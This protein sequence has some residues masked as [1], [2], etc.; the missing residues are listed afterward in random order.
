MN[1]FDTKLPIHSLLGYFFLISIF[2]TF[3]LGFTING[4]PYFVIA[5]SLLVLPVTYLLLEDFLSIK[6]T[7]SLKE[8]AL[9]LT[10]GILL[11]SLLP[12]TS[13]SLNTD[14]WY[15]FFVAY[16][17]LDLVLD[18]LVLYF[19]SLGKQSVNLIFHIYS[20]VLS[21]A[22]LFFFLVFLRFKVAALLLLTL[23]ML[24]V[25]LVKIKLGLNITYAPHPELRTLPLIFLGA[26]G[27]DSS[28]FKFIGILP[29][30]L[31]FF[32]LQRVIQNKLKLFLIVSFSVFMPVVFFNIA[33]IEYSIW[34]YSYNVI[35][36][37]EFYRHRENEIPP[38]NLKVLILI[39]C[40][41]CFVRQTAFFSF[42]PIFVY[43]LFNKKWEHLYLFFLSAS[44]PALQFLIN[45][46]YGLTATGDL[47]IMEL[48]I[49]SLTY[50]ALV[51]TI[52][53]FSF[54]LLFVLFLLIPRASFKSFNYFLYSY[55][56][57]FWIVFHLI[58]PIVWGLPKYLTEYIAPLVVT[59]LFLLSEKKDY[60]FY[61]LIGLS[62][63]FSFSEIS[64][65]YKE[66]GADFS[67]EWLMVKASSGD[68][69][70]HTQIGASWD[71]SVE[72][73]PDKL[74]S[75]TIFEGEI[76]KSTPLVFNKRTSLMDYLNS[77]KL[78]LIE[79][80]NDYL[81]E[82][83]CDNIL[84]SLNISKPII[85]VSQKKQADSEKIKNLR[86]GTVISLRECN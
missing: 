61:P 27:I 16:S 85:I 58:D 28:V 81:V 12:S 35:L 48:V 86:W 23:L 69:K 42:V 37:V 75:R 43:I 17:P 57:V 55:L 59:S 2:W 14:H 80:E 13:E 67:Q 76:F 70:Y 68:R 66:I 71:E 38:E 30:M 18:Q 64:K 40:L 46:S 29:I 83:S 63:I 7:V 51:P 25:M 79:S 22:V 77:K 53:N 54:L 11:Y 39:L 10:S 41:V 56:F 73:I 36:L 8:I 1:F 84:K 50:A 19:P 49:K 44:L 47:P 52:V 82:E 45:I 34:L 31:T 26:F 60:V 62:L 65:N 72:S 32:Y 24:I 9:I 5:T 21:L 33:I 6:L 78:D 15:H 3:F 4:S 74:L 20:L